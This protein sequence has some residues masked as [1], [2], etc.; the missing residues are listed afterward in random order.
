MG[1]KS[2]T[3]RRDA[4]EMKEKEEGIKTKKRSTGEIK[5][6]DAVYEKRE[7]GK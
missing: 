1:G 4:G 3:K 2:Q 6:Y 5:D 7:D